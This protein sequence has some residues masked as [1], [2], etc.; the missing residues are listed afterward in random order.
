MLLMVTPQA[1]FGF[2]FE[3]ADDTRLLVGGRWHHIS[4]ATLFDSN[5]GRDSLLLYLGLSLPLN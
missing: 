2:T 5:P 3:V 1:G 4:N